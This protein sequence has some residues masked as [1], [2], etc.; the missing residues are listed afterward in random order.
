MV[1]LLQIIADLQIPKCFST[2]VTESW[3]FVLSIIIRKIWGEIDIANVKD[4]G[5]LQEWELFQSLKHWGLQQ[6]LFRESCRFY[7]SLLGNVLTRRSG[8]KWIWTLWE[9]DRQTLSGLWVSSPSLSSL[10]QGHGLILVCPS[11]LILT[12]RSCAWRQAR[13]GLR[14]GLGRTE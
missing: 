11:W 7:Q 3:K 5:Y 1:H 10:V 14:K 9:W 6:S 13:R 4:G 12:G 8:V 2:G